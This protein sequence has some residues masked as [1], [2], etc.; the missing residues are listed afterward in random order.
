MAVRA[1]GPPG[2]RSIL[3]ILYNYEPFHTAEALKRLL[4]GPDGSDSGR[5]TQRRVELYDHVSDALKRLH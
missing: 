5:G 2:Q 4:I 1:G 3:I